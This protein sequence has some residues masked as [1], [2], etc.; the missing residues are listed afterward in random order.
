[1]QEKPRAHKKGYAYFDSLPSWLNWQL[2]H[3]VFC[4]RQAHE[5]AYISS[6][7]R[8]YNW[9]LLRISGGTMLQSKCL[10]HLQTRKTDRR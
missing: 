4:L 10:W 9:E 5:D 2:P 1:M 3:F 6:F 8:H 7:I